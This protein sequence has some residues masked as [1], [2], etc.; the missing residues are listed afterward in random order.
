MQIILFV[1]LTIL[2]LMLLFFHLENPKDYWRQGA[3]YLVIFVLGAYFLVSGIQ[4]QTGW[5]ITKVGND[6]IATIVNTDLVPPNQGISM[7]GWLGIALGLYG[8]IVRVLMP[9]LKDWTD[10]GGNYLNS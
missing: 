9:I 7:F 1:F 4:Y 8:I 2:S 3:F 6:T 5:Q 10:A